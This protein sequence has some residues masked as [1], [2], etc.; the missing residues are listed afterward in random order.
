MTRF[1]RSASVL[2]LWQI[3]SISPSYA[4]PKAS[5]SP[6][7]TVV[8]FQA[9]NDS[10]LILADNY[11]DAC[12]DKPEMASVRLNQIKTFYNR[13]Q[14]EA[15]DSVRAIVFDMF[16]NYTEQSKTAR[17]DA[18][19]NIFIALAPDTDEH[20]GPLYSHQIL[21]AK[22]NNDTAS[23]KEYVA[24]LDDYAKRMGY[25]YD[26]EI[27]DAE[28][29]LKIIR[30]RKPIMDILPGVWVSEDIW[31]D[32]VLGFS[33][34]DYSLKS[35]L[36]HPRCIAN[37]LA[38]LK[39]PKAKNFNELVARKCKGMT[40]NTG[41][42][43]LSLT[44]ALGGIKGW[45]AIPPEELKYYNIGKETGTD[46]YRAARPVN[47]DSH[48]YSQVCKI[49]NSAY[50]VYFFWGD[51]SM[52]RPNADISSAIRQSVQNT[53]AMIAGELSRSKYSTEERLLG[54]TFVQLTASGI[55]AVMDA[56]MVSTTRLMSVET[57][58]QIVNPFELKAKTYLQIVISK[59]N[60]SQ[61]HDFYYVFESTYYRWEPE[62]DI[63][64]MG[65]WAVKDAEVS[66]RNYGGV[67]T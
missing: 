61:P 49:D 62:D 25:D 17:A 12:I 1:L 11:A 21:V 58:I 43:I 23:V 9:I 29:F 28:K 4:A 40:I 18:F 42:D 37:S 64:F 30:T 56:L 22:E 46:V 60:E 13:Q 3:L 47:L 35:V 19:R 44:M 52:R 63:A 41:D 6:K 54:N 53:Q 36:Y 38:I 8:N 65:P 27:G 31:K 20:L 59:S 57:I 16:A 26:E 10:V 48:E 45:S 50:G 24:L 66:A 15:Q 33:Y 7:A 14:Q 55:N 67:L 34:K 39:I 2:M 5:P 51:E 32:R